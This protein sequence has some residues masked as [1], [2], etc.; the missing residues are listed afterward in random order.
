M[1]RRETQ[2]SDSEREALAE[3]AKQKA[4]AQEATGR[5]LTFAQRQL[6]DAAIVAA[7]HA[8]HEVR[9]VAREFSLTARQIRNIEKSFKERPTPLDSAPMEII[10][11]LLRTYESQIS[12]FA[13]IANA[14]LETRP[15]I[16]VRALQGEAD[17]TERYANLLGDIGK[18]PDN[19][20]LF[21]SESEMRAVGERMVESLHELAAGDITIGDVIDRFE[22]MLLSPRME[23][24]AE[25]TVQ[26]LGAGEPST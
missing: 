5:A 4:L 21:R 17:A 23:F 22:S 2:P 3:A 16:A 8:G 6:R 9:Q 7:L 10:E 11:R 20:E 19:L 18:L 12:R 14:Q 24:D 26:E 13:A 1:P 15:S 25:A